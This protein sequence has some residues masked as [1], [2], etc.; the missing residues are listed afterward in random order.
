MGDGSRG[1][2]SNL[3][4]KNRT[5]LH[6]SQARCQNAPQQTWCR[7]LLECTNHQFRARFVAPIMLVGRTALS[8]EIMTKSSTPCLIAAWATATV[9]KMLFFDGRK[10]MPFHH[11][12][13]CRRRLDTEW[14]LIASITRR[15]VSGCKMFPYLRVKHQMGK[16]LLQLPVNLKSGDSAS[17]KPTRA[18]DRSGASAGRSLTRSS[19][20]RQSP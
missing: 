14:T 8:V 5:T 18:T 7:P 2:R 10:N 4:L 16:G 12:T 3:F 20:L 11:R 17:S 1:P 13:A 15:R 6:C 9:P 19:R